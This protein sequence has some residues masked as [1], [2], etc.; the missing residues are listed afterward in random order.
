MSRPH[1]GSWNRLKNRTSAENR[2][3]TTAD[4]ALDELVVSIECIEHGICNPL[5]GMR[6]I[7]A[8]HTVVLLQAF[9]RIEPYFRSPRTAQDVA[10]SWASQD[11]YS[12]AQES[13]ERASSMERLKTFLSSRGSGSGALNIGSPHGG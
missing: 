7:G 8:E 3:H 10:S 13:A 9:E 4:T 5:L 2:F 6:H 11:K 12:S 1:F